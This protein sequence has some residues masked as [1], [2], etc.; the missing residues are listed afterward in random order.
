MASF[1]AG[2]IDAMV[3][4]G[5]LIQVPALFGLLPGQGHATLLGTNKISSVVGTSFAAYRY[6]K[7]IQVPWNAVLP[8]TVMALFG[9]YAGAYVVTQISTE[10]L[11]LL[12]PV[13]LVAVALYTFVRKD[14]GSVHA[15]KYTREHER[16]FGALLGL[17]IGFYDGFFGPGTGSFLMVAF[18]VFFGFDFL[19]A[20]AGAKMVNVACNLASLAWFAPSGHVLVGLGLVMAVFNLAGARVG[21]GLAIRKGAGF[22]RKALLLVVCLLIIKTGHD[23]YGPYLLKL[24]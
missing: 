16:L 15:P 21:A 17:A 6:S 18:V 24:F 13:L 10:V 19:A 22:V 12:L 3:G 11:R 8:A 1:G 7:A 4:G 9:A 23:S 14:L 5:G 2:L 20:T